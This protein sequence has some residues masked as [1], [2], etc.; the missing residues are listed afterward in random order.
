MD[1]WIKE[2]KASCSSDILLFLTGNKSDLENYREVSTEEALKL[3]K[4]SDIL[5]FVETSAK[6][7]ENV[8]KMFIDVAKFI[9]L[10]YKDKLHKMVDDENS[11]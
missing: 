11:S 3:K 6:S 5:Y 7:G 4:N 10:K 9:Y 8:D 1:G 2:A